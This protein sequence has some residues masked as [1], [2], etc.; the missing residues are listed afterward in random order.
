MH[1]P[2]T[3]GHESLEGDSS[4]SPIQSEAWV[5]GY[6]CECVVTKCT[7]CARSLT[8]SKSLNYTLARTCKNINEMLQ[9]EQT[10]KPKIIQKYTNILQNVYTQTHFNIYTSK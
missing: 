4:F 6:V 1:L 2:P 8:K 5:G 10:V 7:V 3:R 9:N